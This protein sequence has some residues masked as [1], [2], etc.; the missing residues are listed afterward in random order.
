MDELSRLRAL[1]QFGVLDTA[2]E[3]RFDRVAAMA[4]SYFSAPIALV[5]L[6]DED[7]QWFKSCIGLDVDQTPREWAFC[8]HAIELGPRK[9]M[10]VEDATKDPR[11]AAN[12]L[13]TGDPNIRFYAGAT[14]TTE[15]G[16]N[17]GTLCV[18][19]TVARSRPSDKDLAH[20]L[21]LADLVVD[22]VLLTQ[23]RKQLDERHQILDLAE[24]LSQTGYWTLRIATSEVF[25]SPQVYAIHG[26]SAD[27]FQPSLDDALNFFAVDDRERVRDVIERHTAAGHGWSFDATIVRPDG[28]ERSVRSVAECQKDSRGEVTGFVG[29]LRD[30]TDE[31]RLFATAIERERRYRLLADHASDIIA[32]YDA[33]ASIRYLSPSVREILGY[34]PDQLIGKPIS[35]LVDPIDRAR[36]VE[37][38]ANASVASTPLPIE[39]RALTNDGSTRWVEARPRFRRNEQDVVIE[40]TDSIRDVTDRHEREIALATARQAAESSERAKADF[41]ANMSH[42]IRTPMNGVIGFTDLLS[43]TLLNPEQRRFVELIAD[44]GRSMMQLLNDILDISKIEAGHMQ[45]SSGPVDL[46]HKL[47]NVV[48]LMEPAA[49]AKGI[50]INARIGDTVPPKIHGDAFRLRQILINLVGN[51]IKFTQQGVIEI[52]VDV[53]GE[54]K[55][56]VEFCV[57]DTGMGIAAAQLEVIFE[58]FSQAN[59]SISRE[60]GGTGLGLSITRQLVELM[61]GALSV[62]SEI[63]MGTAFTVR[64]PCNAVSLLTQ[65]PTPETKNEL[66][67]VGPTGARVLVADDVPIN[68]ALMVAMGKQLGL[69][70]EIAENGA[71]AV[72]MIEAAAEAGRPYDLVLMDIQM[73]VLDGLSATRELR[74]RGIT[75]ERL[76]V[77]AITANAFPEDVAQCLEAG[78][79]GHLSKPLKKAELRAIIDRYCFGE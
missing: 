29:V 8:H 20:L 64:L 66:P 57:S 53:A 61:G 68:Q 70:F 24:G 2:A 12:P 52:A 40:I 21:A 34:D 44:S 49:A 72:S 60:F 71:N 78:M 46:R 65:D 31:R 26:I 35:E 43:E 38:F 23:S 13:V 6:V 77:V 45:L 76:P 22:Q 63:G 56:W 32:V 75:P 79:Q 41:L 14:L 55:E 28:S 74:E 30:L 69:A 73:P 16:A 51:A 9:V 62:E 37:Q 15:S 33:N 17:L 18:I 54:S 10:V 5:S 39:Y 59:A 47:R 50:V 27:E 48:Q 58:K 7:R 25:W 4:A 1:H 19:D 42:E 67:T 11:F 3:A 36:V